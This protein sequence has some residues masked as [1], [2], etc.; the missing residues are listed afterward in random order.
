MDMHEPV[1]RLWL[2][3]WLSWSILE[4]ILARRNSLELSR[5]FTSMHNTRR[6]HPNLIRLSV[7]SNDWTVYILTLGLL[8]EFSCDVSTILRTHGCTNSD[9]LV[10]CAVPKGH[11]SESHGRADIYTDAHTRDV[12]DRRRDISATDVSYQYR[13]FGLLPY[14]NNSWA[15]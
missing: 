8:T 1:H 9:R 3:T 14:S 2:L 6:N 12:V 10:A 15:W 7:S 11:M 5:P 4:T 13:Q